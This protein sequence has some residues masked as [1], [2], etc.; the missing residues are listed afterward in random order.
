LFAFV[1]SRH[2]AG[3][4]H[5]YVLPMS[6]FVLLAAFAVVAVGVAASVQAQSG[7]TRDQRSKAAIQAAEGGV[8]QA[9]LRYN[10]YAS[11]VSPLTPGLPCIGPAATA[12][13]AGAGG[14]CAGV[15]AGSATYYAHPA[16]ASGTLEIVSV[17]NV[18]GVT[19][20]VDVT[21]TSASGQRMFFTAGV[22]AEDGITLAANASI[23]S[24]VKTNGNMGLSSNAE[25]CGPASVGLAGSLSLL[26]NAT[27]FTD[28]ACT[29]AASA[30]SVGH[31]PLTLPPVNAGDSAVNNDDARITNAAAGS[32]SPA[33]LVS[34]NRAD[35]T[36]SSTARTLTIDH[37]SA[38]TLTG[39]KYS[40]C[41]ITLLQ[42]SA[43]YVA[44]GLTVT[45]FFDSPE[46]CGL[47]AGTPQLSLA[48]NS[49][50][51]P[52][53]GNP[54]SVAMLF[55]GSPVISTNMQMSSNT[56]VSGACVQN[57]VIYAPLTDITLNSN[58]QYCG[59][60][61]G[62]SIALS[63]NAHIQ[64]DSVSQAYTLP[65]TA[66]HYALSRFVECSAAPATPPNSGC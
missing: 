11:A 1:N 58:S 60:M 18:S 39:T 53:S 47:P 59:A 45:M 50:I 41:R 31:A 25:Q 32:G 30:S 37:N 48:S 55:V 57:F 51:S 10:T 4:Q 40:F 54:S 36:W 7:T 33:D 49:R 66:P 22:L 43:I 28:S 52:A 44:A 9:L 12:T 8:S 13:A 35:V 20:R 65:A 26:G 3:K 61:A 6:L 27:Y 63:S 23:Q 56:Q 38:L 42:N 46:L 62:K 16:A 29:A 5:G 24:G 15:T 2:P 17:G 34:G 19:R 21:A 14:W 64:T